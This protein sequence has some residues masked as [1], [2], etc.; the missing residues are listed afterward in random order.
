MHITKLHI[1]QFRCF[2]EYSLQLEAPIILLC[3]Q[4]GSGKTSLLEALHYGCYLRSFRTHLPRQ[5]VAHGQDTFFVGIQFKEHD[6][7]HEL[8]AGFSK[9]SKKRLVKID[10]QP[11]ETYKQLTEHYRIVTVT[12]DDLQLI[13]SGP[14]LRRTFIDQAVALSQPEYTATLRTYKQIVANRNALIQKGQCDHDTYEAWTEQLWQHTKIIQTQRA[15]QLAAIQTRTNALLKEFV[16]ESLTVTFTYRPRLIG[17]ASNC[18][19]FLNTK[20]NLMH[21]EHAM[22]RSLFGAHLDDIAIHFQ[23][24]GSKAFASRGQQKL[25]VLLLKIAQ[26][27]E[28]HATKGPAILL[29]DD[30]MTDFDTDRITA[31]LEMLASLDCQLILTS[32]LQGG[33]FTKALKQKGAQMVNLTP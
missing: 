21:Q 29:L 4:N 12:S 23:E 28:L 7:T 25:I 16:S 27:Q 3:G 24:K 20:P 1:K 18:Q 17:E 31:L 14:R 30:F 6:T 19:E 32:P 33:H 11:I 10:Q 26:L 8:N 9:G 5:L 22:N 2:S 15:E 13:Q